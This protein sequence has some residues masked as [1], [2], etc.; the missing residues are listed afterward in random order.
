MSPHNHQKSQSTLNHLKGKQ[1]VEVN[2]SKYVDR[3]V[4]QHV[5][6][7]V[8][9]CACGLCL[10]VGVCVDD[11]MEV[12]VPKSGGEIMKRGNIKLTPMRPTQLMDVV[13]QKA[14]SISGWWC[15]R[16]TF[17]ISHGGKG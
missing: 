16:M 12:F 15:N 2:E 4:G 7:E 17:S 14:N 6:K 13:S 1:L 5:G 3:Y 11:S 9:P 10:C 8:C